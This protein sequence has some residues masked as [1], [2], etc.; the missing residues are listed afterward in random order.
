MVTANLPDR[1]RFLAW[2]PSARTDPPEEQPSSGEPW[3]LTGIDP[4]ACPF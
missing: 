4:D 3:N 2:S 1:A